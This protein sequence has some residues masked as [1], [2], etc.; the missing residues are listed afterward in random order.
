MFAREVSRSAHQETAVRQSENVNFATIA[1]TLLGQENSFDG[2]LSTLLSSGAQLTRVNFA[3]QLSQLNQEL[4]NWRDVADMMR[5]PALSPALNVTLS[6]AT[7]VRVNDYD[8]I[9]A[10][11]ASAL[12]LTGPAAPASLSL[13]VAQ[14]SLSQ[15]AATWGSERHLLASAPGHVTLAALSNQTGHLNVPQDVATLASAPNLA[16]TRAIVISAIKV[17]PAPFPAPALTLLI[18]PTSSFQVQVAVSNLREIVQPITLSMTLTPAQGL[19]QR[20][21]MTQTLAPV[22]SFAFA[23][24]NF[25]VFP[26]ESATLTVAINGLPPTSALTH[27]RTYVVKVSPS[28]AG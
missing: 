27:S 8:R 7:L 21:S 3:V 1:T 14:L 19:V 22:T 28:A 10:Y 11:V 24:H 17:Q 26:G 5:S 25:S 9:L 15:T 2:R 23:G 6:D 12:S 20:V 13:G 18:A 16:A 4:A